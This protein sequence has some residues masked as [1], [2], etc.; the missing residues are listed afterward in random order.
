MPTCSETYGQNWVGEYPN[1]RYESP[2][3]PGGQQ[4]QT[5]F[6]GTVGSL[7]YGEQLAGSSWEDDWQQFFDPFD[8]GL[9]EQATRAA[10]IDIGQLQSAWD[11]QS[12][13]LEEALGLGREQQGEAWRLQAGGLGEQWGGRQQELGAGARRGYQD[14]TRMGEQMLT[15][16]RGLT[17]GEQSQRQ[18]EEEVSGSYARAF[19]LGQSAYEQAIESGQSRY[20]QALEAGTMGYEQALETGELALQQGTT[21]IYQ[22]LESDFLG[23]EQDWLNQSRATLNVLLGSGIWSGD[24][25][26]DGGYTGGT[27]G[28]PPSGYQ[29]PNDPNTGAVICCDGSEQ[30]A[31]YMCGYGNQPAD[32]Y[33]G[34]TSTGGDTGTGDTGTGAGTTDTNT[35]SVT[36]CDGSTVAMAALCG[37]G[38]QPWDCPP[39]TEEG[40]TSPPAG[41]CTDPNKSYQCADGTCVGSAMECIDL[42]GYVAPKVSSGTP[43]YSGGGF[44]G[45][46]E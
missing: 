31:A 40:G 45:E 42:S 29:D 23:F 26:G 9:Q 36:C 17:F 15:R 33:G 13:Q 14:V 8:W 39:G 12:G 30:P 35:G 16:G 6:T 11:L 22:G 38:N 2:T 21:D 25:G 46:D 27:W 34:K 3:S 24:Q 28:D 5:P 10:G 7:G 44:G 19:G 37:I 32:C 4:E 43:S 41:A 20:R 1:C 18:A